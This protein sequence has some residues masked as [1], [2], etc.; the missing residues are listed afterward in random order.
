MLLAGVVAAVTIGGPASAGDLRPGQ[1]SLGGVQRI[2]LKADGAWYGV[3]FAFAGRWR[4]DT[5]AAPL[6]GGY[7]SAAGNR[8]H[9][10]VNV[11][12]GAA[13]WYEW[14]EGGR[15]S[16]LLPAVSFRRLGPS[17]PPAA[18]VLPTRPATQ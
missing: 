13:D 5:A 10:T 7:Q 3:T 1:Y 2:C 14:S 12:N 6:W 11:A 8:F 16:Q 4:N 17:C 18:T 15:Y 9:D